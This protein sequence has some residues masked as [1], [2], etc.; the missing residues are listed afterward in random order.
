MR[1][2]DPRTR[3]TFQLADSAEEFLIFLA[4]FAKNAGKHAVEL[5]EISYKLEGKYQLSEDAMVMDLQFTL[6]DEEGGEEPAG[7]SL[8]AELLQHGDS[9]Y[10]KAVRE[11]G[12]SFHFSEILR[13]ISS[14]YYKA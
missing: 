6:R 12:S 5:G 13:L 2:L 10:C 7:C 8:K 11:S 3:P 9:L 1:E 14:S 4:D